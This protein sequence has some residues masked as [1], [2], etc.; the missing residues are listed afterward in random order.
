MQRIHQAAALTFMALSGFVVV[1]SLKMEYYTTLGPG[2]GF[3]PFWLGL[4]LGGLSLVWFFQVS[5]KSGRPEDGAFLPGKKGILQI[6]CILL[7]LFASAFL[8][9]IIGFQLT[10]FL[11]L[12]FL[13][14]VLG[15]SSLWMTL[16]IAVIFSVG[17]YRVFGGYLDVQLPAASLA[18]LSAL[19]L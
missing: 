13:L 11:F 16:I 7:A 1:A 14:R 12:V 15:Q 3:F 4:V 10:M 9:D 17:V 6:L 18:A 19:G 5:G 2:P 8:M